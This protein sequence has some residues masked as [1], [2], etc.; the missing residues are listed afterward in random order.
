MILC[1]RIQYISPYTG[2]I[3]Y[4]L[5]PKPVSMTNAL[6]FYIDADKERELYWTRT[7]ICGR[8]AN[9]EDLWELC[10]LKSFR[11]MAEARKHI[12][13]QCEKYGLIP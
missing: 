9:G 1:T 8:G 3:T 10:P 5:H 13:S 11:S 7:S 4:T 12:I 6:P 2:A